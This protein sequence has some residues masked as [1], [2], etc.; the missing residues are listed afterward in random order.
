MVAYFLFTI[1]KHLHN[2]LCIINYK[3]C[4]YDVA[5]IDYY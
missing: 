3:V 4:N 5:L 2:I 1:G